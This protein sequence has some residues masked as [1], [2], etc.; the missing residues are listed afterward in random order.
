[1]YTKNLNK[2][3]SVAFVLPILGMAF[4][5]ESEAKTYNF[6]ESISLEKN[7]EYNLAGLTLI[8]N[9][10]ISY[11]TIKYDSLLS[12]N[13]EYYFYN[14][15]NIK[16]NSES[17]RKYDEHGIY[18]YL[19]FHEVNTKKKEDNLILLE[20]YTPFYFF[21]NG[22]IL[23]QNSINY[24][25]SLFHISNLKKI[26]LEDID[27]PIYA[28]IHNGNIFTK[29]EK[30][31]RYQNGGYKEYNFP[32]GGENVF[33][34]DIKGNTIAVNSQPNSYYIN[35]G[36]ENYITLFNFNGERYQEKLVFSKLTNVLG[37][38]ISGDGRIIAASFI[39]N[40]SSNRPEKPFVFD[41]S[42]PNE[43]IYLKDKNGNLLTPAVLDGPNSSDRYSSGARVYAL[44]YDGTV[45][46]GELGTRPYIWR[47][48]DWKG[49][50]LTFNEHDRGTVYSISGDGRLATGFVY[51]NNPEGYSSI[52]TMLWRITPVETDDPEHVSHPADDPDNIEERPEISVPSIIGI[53][54]DNTKQSMK[55]M[56]RD[57]L[58]LF[59][60]QYEALQR[61]QRSCW[62]KEKQ[63]CYAL[64]QQNVFQQG[65]ADYALGLRLGY[66]VTER[67]TLGVNIDHSL[68]RLLPKTY[69]RLNS[70]G[71]MGI[72]IHYQLPRKSYLEAA[73][74]WDIYS[75]QASRPLL[76]DTEFAPMLTR[77]KGKKWHIE[78]GKNTTFM[79]STTV[80]GY[81]AYRLTDIQREGYHE[82]VLGFPV[83]YGKVQLKDHRIAL[84]FIMMKP[85]SPK[86]TW[87]NRIDIERH[88]GGR[89]P[90]YTANA[91]DI[92]DIQHEAR[93]NK[94][95]WRIES[96]LNYQFGSNFNISFTPYTGNSLMGH[97]QWGSLLQ[98]EG[99]F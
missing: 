54:L 90:L 89:S 20:K 59:S 40:S 88:I 69:R 31:L 5:F 1:M 48:P 32:Y 79:N 83:N 21:N 80:G 86:L 12:N 56:G 30:I 23:A 76:A 55:E 37:S 97:K 93:L 52:R 19:E 58:S 62:A 11:F 3:K 51:R 16:F 43:I 81:I 35:S 6:I 27:I 74:A 91:K 84:G 73:V 24:T 45:A 82:D 68:K 71:G 33:G 50:P 99:R 26:I 25:F 44:N 38:A 15:S 14:L 17:S 57:T 75:V 94:I 39:S 29:N 63:F 61:L 47:G 8:N 13:N 95:Q 42:K 9:K 65:K 85:L 72:F 2:F 22:Y 96:G 67:L 78:W 98:I 4:S 92:A 77:I 66:G 10:N 28:D 60:L 46:A 18:T 41:V 87:R 34:W 36:R 7:K 64:S 53:D 49:V 70:N